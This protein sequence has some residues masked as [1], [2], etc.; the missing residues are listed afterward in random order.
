MFAIPDSSTSVNQKFIIA[1]RYGATYLGIDLEPAMISGTSTGPAI[2]VSS[3]PGSASTIY[4]N[5][6]LYSGLTTN[7]VNYLYVAGNSSGN[8]PGIQ[9]LGV[10]DDIDV[11]V[12]PK[13]AGVFLLNYGPVALGAGAAATLGT[14]GGSGPQ[15]AAQA[16]WVKVRAGDGKHYFLPGFST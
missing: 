16:V 11:Q 7:G 12:L 6:I 8:E 15:V 10:D 2:R 14:I 1:D 5:S 4:Y 9:A 13:G 3:P